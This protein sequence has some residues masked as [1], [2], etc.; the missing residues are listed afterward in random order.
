MTVLILPSAVIGNKRVLEHVEG[1]HPLIYTH[2]VDS[3]SFVFTLWR[4]QNSE[5]IIC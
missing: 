3:G 1:G 2:H 5:Y 4:I